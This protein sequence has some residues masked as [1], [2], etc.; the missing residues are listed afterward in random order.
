MLLSKSRA[1]YSR[2]C[3]QPGANSNPDSRSQWTPA[4]IS[5]LG[6]FRAMARWTETPM[7]LTAHITKLEAAEIPSRPVIG[8][9][10]NEG[11]GEAIAQGAAMSEGDD[12]DDGM[13]ALM[14]A[15]AADVS[16]HA[17][18]VR[19]GIS[20]D[21]AG[22]I[23][24]A[25]KTLPPSQVAG[26]VAALK[27]SMAAALATSQQAATI[28]MQARQKAAMVQGRRKRLRVVKGGRKPWDYQPSR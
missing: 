14:A 22:R 21:F 7:T 27:A 8:A 3:I 26:A 5:V 24:H 2:P 4:R 23:A 9:T 15:I 13:K 16:A 6:E 1:D 20:A 10:T 12:A 19:D 11:A 25:T 28:E 18:A 17:A